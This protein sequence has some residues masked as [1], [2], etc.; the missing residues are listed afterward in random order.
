ML[1]LAHGRDPIT[2]IPLPTG[3]NR[4]SAPA[5]PRVPIDAQVYQLAIET[6]VPAATQP[7]MWPVVTVGQLPG[8]VALARSPLFAPPISQDKSCLPLLPGH[9]LLG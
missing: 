2:H 9:A 6:A 4:C 1:A 8:Q 3:Y 5:V 7:G